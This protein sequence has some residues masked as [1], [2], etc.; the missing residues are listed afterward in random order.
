MGKRWCSFDEQVAL[1][2]ERGLRI[3]DPE[4]AKRLLKQVGYYRLSEYL[5]YWQRDPERGD[6]TFVDGA[7]FETV[8]GVYAGETML[9]DVAIAA[10]R[11]LELVLRTQ[12]AHAFGQIVGPY[13][14]LTADDA[15]TPPPPSATGPSAQEALLRDLNRSR[16]PF[17]DRYRDSSRSDGRGGFLPDAYER[18]PAWVAV[19]ACS[20]GTLSRCLEASGRTAVR[21]TVASRIGTGRAQIASQTRA[22]VYLRN[23]C[24]HAARIWNH[25]V[26]AAPSLTP[27]TASR[28]KRQYRTFENR[29]VYQ[30][31][32][33]I[34]IL[35]AGNGQ[36]KDWLGARIEP[37]LRDNEILAR[38][39][40]RPRKFQDFTP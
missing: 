14:L 22:L 1:L 17:V 2:A 11:R 10:L 13:R 21:D 5:H 32:V 27:K 26:L 9:A 12:F 6:K 38:G 28:I 4:A 37:I 18:M 33:L 31:L 39:I 34:H 25:S 15:F 36:E 8:R 23:R 3:R 20:F 24:A 7:S 16:E 29:S 40:T 30:T 19:Q 35:L